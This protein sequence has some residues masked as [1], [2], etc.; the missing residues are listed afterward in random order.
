MNQPRLWLFG[1][2]THPYNLN[3]TFCEL[4]WTQD[5]KKWELMDLP[6]QVAETNILAAT[7]FYDDNDQL[8][9]LAGI[10]RSEQSIT[11]SDHKLKDVTLTKGKW[12][13]GALTDFGW[14]N[15]VDLF[16]IRSVS[17]R[18]RWILSPV[19]QDWDGIKSYNAMIYTTPV[20]R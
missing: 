18:D 4:W 2:T 3:E 6:V 16:Q 13:E 20:K 15:P 11:T 1:G 10:F 12:S 9:H 19:Y 7:I 8:L 17:F 5:G 14:D